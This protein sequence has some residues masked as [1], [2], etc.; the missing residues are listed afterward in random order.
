MGKIEN[1]TVVKTY[2]ESKCDS[3]K[4]QSHWNREAFVVLQIGDHSVTVLGEDL[5]RAI[6]NCMNV[7]F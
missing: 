5:K 4:V 7:G 2:E 3:V 6:Q 1:Y